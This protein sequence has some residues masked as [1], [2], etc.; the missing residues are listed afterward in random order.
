MA[1]P[2]IRTKLEYLL[3]ALI[4]DDSRDLADAE[5]FQC[6]MLPNNETAALKAIERAREWTAPEHPVIPAPYD[7][8]VVT[9][10]D[11]VKS[12]AAY[13]DDWATAVHADN[14]LDRYIAQHSEA[15]RPR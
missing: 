3:Y 4:L 13:R 12:D 1:Y 10:L 6:E 11:N 9:I 7:H 5:K 14:V 15:G 2:L 8:D